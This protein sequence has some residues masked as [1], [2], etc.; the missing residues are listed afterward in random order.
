MAGPNILLIMT[1]QHNAR[2]LSC[3]GE[4]V[5]QTPNID[6]LAAEGV[7]FTNAFA[8]SIHCG[9]S[10]ISFLTGMYEHSHRRHRNR[11]E[12]PDHLNPITSLLRNA[13]YRTAIIGK[14]HLGVEWPRR[15]FDHC[16]F[17]F[18]TDSLC[19]EP[20]S[21]HYFKFL[22]DHGMADNY[23]LGTN[24]TYSEQPA[25][26]SPLPLDYCEE[27]W[28]GNEAVKYIESEGDENPYFLF[29]SFTRPHNPLTVPAPYDR[30]YDPKKIQLPPN[31]N[32]TCQGK[33]ERQQQGARGE[34]NYPFRPNDEGELRKCLSHYYGL[35]SL[36][37]R[38]VG[39]VLQTL[40]ERGQLD[41]TLVIFTSDHGDFAGEH[42]FMY[43]NLGFYDAIHRIPLVIRYPRAFR[44]NQT[45]DPFV[46]SVDLYPT[47]TQILNFTD[48][49]TVQ[50]R[51]FLDA[52]RDN[53]AWNKQTSICEHVKSGT[54][55]LSL[56]NHRYRLTLDV[57]PFIGTDES[58]LYDYEIDPQ[59][60]KNC[61]NDPAYSGVREKLL[62][63]LLRYRA[64]PV[65]LHGVPQ[66]QWR[67]HDEP[68]YHMPDW[69]G[70][71][72]DIYHG[73]PWSQI[74]H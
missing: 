56:R 68:N 40:T 8:N 26:T 67:P 64:C 66:G 4:P 73:V 17:S 9:P 53:A 72:M 5:L 27:E 23:D 30:M 32:D 59:E 19:N 42:G 22:V 51:S 74:E 24:Y 11:D 2:C 37:D 35:V 29:M 43:K 52:V 21:C 62:I 13:G 20:L 10:R 1:D 15:Q 69:G 36:I 28:I 41:N 55:H 48:P 70:A 3:A 45:F 33:A 44:Q 57:A 25:I 12:P 60:L 38:Q 16:R 50:G 49:W 6:R 71:I 39:R 46:E 18:P 14:G 34:L 65:L 31:W 58:E 54:Y 47:L 61:W 63:E 7:R